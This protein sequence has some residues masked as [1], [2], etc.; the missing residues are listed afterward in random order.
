[1]SPAAAAGLYAERGNCRASVSD[2]KENTSPVFSAGRDERPK[3]RRVP[4]RSR[5]LTH[6]SLPKADVAFI[7]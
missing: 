3:F 1:M 6:H 4:V 5:L 2:N 7:I